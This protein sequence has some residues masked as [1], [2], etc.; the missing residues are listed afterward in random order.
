MWI[1]RKRWKLTKH[2]QIWLLYRL[3]FAIEWDHCECCTLWLWHNFQGQIFQMQLS[4]KWLAKHASYGFYRFWYLPLNG[5][6]P[7]VVLCDVSLLFQGQIFQMLI[8][9]KRC[10]LCKYVTYN[11]YRRWYLPSKS[12]HC[13]NHTLRPWLA[14]SWSKLQI[15][16]KVVQQICLHLHGIRR[17]VALALIGDGYF[18]GSKFRKRRVVLPHIHLTREWIIFMDRFR[19]GVKV[20]L[21]VNVIF[22]LEWELGLEFVLLLALGASNK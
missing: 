15:F 16:T 17:R 21:R 2:A 11:F 5:A 10:E 7:K 8:S 12:N 19:I 22:R 9:R 1:S 13:E 6:I 18:A 3:I 14:I 4:L 20:M